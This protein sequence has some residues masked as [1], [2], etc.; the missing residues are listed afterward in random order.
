[1]VPVNIAA[2]ALRT[3]VLLLSLVALVPRSFAQPPAP[4]TAPTPPSTASLSGFITDTDGASIAQARLTL[5]PSADLS[6]RT[7]LTTLTTSDGGFNFPAVPT[8]SFTLSIAA[9][10]FVLRQITGTLLPGESRQL[11]PI[12]LHSGAT[13]NIQVS[14]TQ[15]D[16]EVA[17]EEKQ[18]VLGVIPN[19]YVSYDPH[20]VPLSPRQKYSLAFKTLIDPISFALT[21][22]T[23]GEELGAHDFAWELGASGYGKRYAAAYGSF[24]TDDILTNAVLP[25]LFKQDPRYLY[26]GTGSIHSRL[27]YA[28]ANGIVCRG[29]NQHWQLN[30]SGIVGSLAA[31]GIANAYYPA[32]NRDGAALT[33]EGLAVG[34]G[35]SAIQNV[36]QEFL[37]P[38]LT[39][40]LPKRS[41]PLTPPPTTP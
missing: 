2:H 40:H 15:G 13:T 1:M 10:G 18:R 38:K 14:A 12:A 36:I 4:A 29:D 39:P 37:I 32:P 17:Q 23:A 25:I 7:I 24:L 27:F 41:H 16:I 11:D 31:G 6:T 34:T 19:F 5:A 33:F 21:G 26:K 9:P 8:G 28:L 20:P 3:S 35:F 22:V 30:Y